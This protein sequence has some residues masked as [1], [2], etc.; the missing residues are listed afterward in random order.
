M[1]MDGGRV[2]SER[3]FQGN[4][5]SNCRAI[6]YHLIILS[7]AKHYDIL[8]ESGCSSYFPTVK[9]EAEPALLQRVA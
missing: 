5:D 8:L 2:L 9:M 3:M 6:H 4:K 1:T 7:G